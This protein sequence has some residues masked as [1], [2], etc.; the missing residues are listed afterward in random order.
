MEYKKVEILSFAVIMII[1]FKFKTYIFINDLLL[2]KIVNIVLITEVRYLDRNMI[3]HGD[4]LMH[5][6]K[7]K[8]KGILQ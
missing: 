3:L 1:V 5:N 2:F 6:A 4:Y 8:L 7:Y